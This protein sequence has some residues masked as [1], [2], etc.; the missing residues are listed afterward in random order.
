M[1]DVA[2][3]ISNAHVDLRIIEIVFQ[4]T[5]S[6]SGSRFLER[7]QMTLHAVQC[8]LDIQGA[9]ALIVHLVIKS[10]NTAKIFHEVRQQTILQYFSL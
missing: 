5:E 6:I 2:L 7:A 1:L 8:H 10:A 4:F 3:H 9:S